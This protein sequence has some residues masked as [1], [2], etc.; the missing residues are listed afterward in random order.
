MAR[1]S[2]SKSPRRIYLREWRES[3][4]EK[5]LRVPEIAAMLGMTRTSY[6]RLEKAPHT[7]S[8]REL[9]ILAE[10]FKIEPGQLWQNP[11]TP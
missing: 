2:R 3:F 1:N 9:E 8:A 5:G 10:A 11:N 4:G 7:L 6:Y